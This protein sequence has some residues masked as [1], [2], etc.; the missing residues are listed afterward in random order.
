MIY[1]SYQFS[2]LHE[3]NKI[4]LIG[5]NISLSGCQSY[6]PGLTLAQ[7]LLEDQWV[8]GDWG[9]EGWERGGCSGGKEVDEFAECAE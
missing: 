6:G 7:I 4:Q 9:D 1:T 2:G 3:T 8:G 5:D